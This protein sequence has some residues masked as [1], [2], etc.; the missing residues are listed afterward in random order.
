M[1][2][3]AS[4]LQFGHACDKIEPKQHDPQTIHLVL[5]VILRQF[6]VQK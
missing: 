6:I 3:V 5:E 2:K 1:P 4:E